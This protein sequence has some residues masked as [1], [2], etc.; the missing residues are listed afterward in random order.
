[1]FNVVATHH[2]PNGKTIK[3][4]NQNNKWGIFDHNNKVII[5]IIYD[6]LICITDPFYDGDL[7]LV[8]HIYLKKGGKFRV[9]DLD[10]LKLSDIFF[11][12]IIETNGNFLVVRQGNC[13]GCVMGNQIS[14]PIVFDEIKSF[15]GQNMIAKEYG[16]WKIIHQDGDTVAILDYDEF[17]EYDFGLIKVRTG[18]F[19][20]IIDY[21]GN[22]VLPQHY[23][24]I[25]EIKDAKSPTFHQ[26]IFSKAGNKFSLNNTNSSYDYYF[27]VKEQDEIKGIGYQLPK[28][29]IIHS[30][31]DMPF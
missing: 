9:F 1:M 2:L 29:N 27:L 20:G 8:I 14:T 15:Y 21:Y 25:F 26:E 4:I 10:N 31:D 18:K 30:T 7:C 23:N 12:E 24:Q 19:W 3:V 16:V 11:D 13:F 6:D 5:D 22:I 17:Q 28:I